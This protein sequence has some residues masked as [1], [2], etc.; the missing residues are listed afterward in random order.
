MIDPPPGGVPAVLA[1]FL[2]GGAVLC[3]GLRAGQ[4]AQQRLAAL[5][6]PAP[7][8]THGS[9]GRLG[10]ASSG[11][12]EWLSWGGCVAV[13]SAGVALLVSPAVAP[14]VPVLAVLAWRWRRARRRAAVLRDTRAFVLE[15]CSALAAE[16]RGG[17]SPIGAL[18]AAAGVMGTGG[19]GVS[20]AG[21]SG[22]GRAASAI[23]SLAATADPAAV[24]EGLASL[25]RLPGG[26]GLAGLAVC[27]GVTG[28]TGAGLAAAVDR[29]AASLRAEAA[30]RREIEAQLSAPR[31]TARLLAGLP[32]VGL[33]AGTVLGADPLA[34]LLGP[35]WGRG[36]LAAGCAMALLGMWWVDRI[37]TVAD[38]SWRR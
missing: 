17:H 21:L 23:Q 3:G 22:A 15:L 33:V 14:A 34:V 31:A 38:V 6:A 1:G 36:C 24:P 11:S 4:P 32:V 29:L 7:W 12:S 25:A 37:A 30:G 8:L 5:L 20:G 27:W 35:S 18:D 16:L 10:S 2:M 13:L 26:E 9:A 19:A 28:G